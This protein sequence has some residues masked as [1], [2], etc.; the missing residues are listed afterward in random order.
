MIASVV[1][2]GFGSGPIAGGE[3]VFEIFVLLAFVL[4][5]T[6]FAWSSRS[7]LIGVI[8]IVTAYLMGTILIESGWTYGAPAFMLSLANGLKLFHTAWTGN[9]KV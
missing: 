8:A 4:G 6:I 5:I 2:I 9:A 7:V 1:H 3:M